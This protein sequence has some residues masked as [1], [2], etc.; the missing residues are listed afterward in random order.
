MTQFFGLFALSG[1]ATAFL[2]PLV[3]A[4]FAIGAFSI[5]GVPPAA[6][7]AIRSRSSNSAMP[8]RMLSSIA[9]C[10]TARAEASRC[11]RDN[12]VMSVWVT[13]KPPCG[14]ISMRCTPPG[15]LR[16]GTD[17]L[18]KE[19]RVGERVAMISL[20]TSPLD[21]PG[22]GDAGGMNVYVVQTA[23]RMARRGIEVEIF[24]RATS[25][26]HA[27]TVELAPGHRTGLTVG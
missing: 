25:S 2:G 3:G 7:A 17:Q 16:T 5:A 23:L 4:A 18:T 10:T 15:A 8:W 12:S 26:E 1:T 6:L 11:A 9:C 20:H 24:T 21:Q 14:P 27:P 19:M 22:T 13:T